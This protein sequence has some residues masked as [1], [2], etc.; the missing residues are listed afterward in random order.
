MLMCLQNREDDVNEVETQ[1]SLLCQS[2]S[3]KP[4]L[5]TVS[6]L[7]VEYELLDMTQHHRHIYLAMWY[8]QFHRIQ[9]QIESRG[10]Y[11]HP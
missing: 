9:L 8:M 2:T 3:T 6:V 11:Y 5:L 7:A 4:S 1:F 10:V